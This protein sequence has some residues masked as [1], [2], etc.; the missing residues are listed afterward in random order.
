MLLAALQAPV[1]FV[2]LPRPGVAVRHLNC[3]ALVSIF[4]IFP[5]RAITRIASIETTLAWE[6]GKPGEAIV[7]QDFK[8]QARSGARRP[9]PGGVATGKVDKASRRVKLVQWTGF[10]SNLI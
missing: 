10:K 7:M 2:G 8:P 5:T 1:P 3:M 6:N 9:Q 4:K